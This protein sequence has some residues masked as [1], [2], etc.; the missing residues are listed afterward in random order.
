[1][2]QCENR[3][4]PTNVI[5][6]ASLVAAVVCLLV[7]ML[8]VASDDAQTEQARVKAAG[9]ALGAW[10]RVRTVFPQVFSTSPNA[11]SFCLR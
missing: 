7:P 6:M 3:V 1:M 9:D 2:T 11:S 4:Q 5:W 10:S 8:A